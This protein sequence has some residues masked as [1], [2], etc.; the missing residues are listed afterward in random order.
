VKVTSQSLKKLG[1]RIYRYIVN[2]KKAFIALVTALAFIIC[3]IICSSYLFY[4]AW[5]LYLIFKYLIFKV[6]PLLWHQQLGLA[7]VILVTFVALIL[8]P[9]VPPSQESQPSKRKEGSNQIVEII[10]KILLIPTLI[11]FLLILVA[12]YIIPLIEGGAISTVPKPPYCQGLIYKN[13]S[14]G[15]ASVSLHAAAKSG[16]NA[17]LGTAILTFYA[18]SAVFAAGTGTT[19]VLLFL[20][21]FWSLALASFNNSIDFACHRE[22][23]LGIKDVLKTSLYIIGSFGVNFVLSYPV[24]LF[25]LATSITSSNLQFVTLYLTI[26]AA[27]LTFITEM[28][29]R[30]YSYEDN[31]NLWNAIYGGLFYLSMFSL[32]AFVAMASSTQYLLCLPGFSSRSF[33]ILLTLASMVG[34]IPF[35][36]ALLT[37]YHYYLCQLAKHKG[38]EFILIQ[39]VVV[40]VIIPFFLLL[41]FYR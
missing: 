37:A 7:L 9:L 35:A 41:S 17:S 10:F 12:I 29:L 5:Y 38:K 40:L 33:E 11:L 1:Q 18:S 16:E 4:A 3:S 23:I 21:Y 15:S 30:R 25:A 14:N 32:L 31:K 8:Y 36:Y 39:L 19:I 2:Q 20:L 34:A 6:F 28:P 22:A 13:A 26:V 27:L 24:V